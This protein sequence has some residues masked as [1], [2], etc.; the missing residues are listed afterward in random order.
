MTHS[1]EKYAQFLQFKET[2][3]ST[4]M[5]SHATAS[6][7]GISGLLASRDSS[8]IID[9]GTSSHMTGSP[10]LYSRISQLLDIRLLSIADARTCRVSGQGT[11]RATS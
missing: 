10:G 5:V 6:T 9:S 1:Q 2:Q 7:L 3:S 8:W 11:I 4:T